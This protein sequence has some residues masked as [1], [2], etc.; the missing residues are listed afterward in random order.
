M[1]KQTIRLIYSYQRYIQRGGI[2]AILSAGTKRNPGRQT[3]IILDYE[4]MT[5][6]WYLQTNRSSGYQV[7]RLGGE[8]RTDNTVSSPHTSHIDLGEPYL[9]LMTDGIRCCCGEEAAR[10][11]WT[12]PLPTPPSLPPSRPLDTQYSNFVL[13]EVPNVG[14]CWTKPGTRPFLLC[15][16]RTRTGPAL[17]T[18]TT[19]TDCLPSWAFLLFLL[20]LIFTSR[21]IPL[22]H[23]PF[24]STATWLYLGHFRLLVSLYHTFQLQ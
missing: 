1:E 18:D 11:A 3:A 7:S 6:L 8:L 23:C 13:S 9:A 20:L 24:D 16:T 5:E 17:I 12:P 10:A 14:S 2:I 21:T 22:T 19:H 4:R 15:P